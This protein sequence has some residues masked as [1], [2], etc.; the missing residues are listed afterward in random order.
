[1]QRAKQEDFLNKKQVFLL[2]FT[3]ELINNSENGLFQLKKI[4]EEKNRPVKE[5]IPPAEIKKQEIKKEEPPLIRSILSEAPRRRNGGELSV[6]EP[7]IPI[8]INRR[9]IS[10]EKQRGYPVLRIPEPTLPPELQYLKPV[11]SNREIDL[12]KLN[13]VIN[14]PLVR[15]IECEGPNKPIIV[16]GG[17]GRKPTGII[18]MNNEIEDII[19]RFSRASKIPVDF[20]I[21]KVVVGNL[22]FSAI[23]SE[24]VPSKFTITKMAPQNQTIITNPNLRKN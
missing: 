7:A 17:M 2:L 1:M 5:E 20:G 24:I 22:I 10:E 19:D 4:L 21:Y 16:S 12:D 13:S 9:E 15:Q 14:D 11:P 3:R 18:L 23:V 6:V 8:K